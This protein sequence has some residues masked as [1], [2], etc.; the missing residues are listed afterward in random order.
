MQSATMQ[1]AIISRATVRTLPPWAN[2]ED[3]SGSP[4]LDTPSST[5]PAISAGSTNGPAATSILHLSTPSQSSIPSPLSHTQQWSQFATMSQISTISERASRTPDT[6]SDTT[7]LLQLQE[8]ADT[9]SDSRF[10]RLPQRLDKIFGGSARASAAGGAS[11]SNTIGPLPSTTCSCDCNC[12]KHR[13]TTTRTRQSWRTGE[14]SQ[15]LLSRKQTAKRER[16]AS[17]GYPTGEC[18]S[19]TAPLVTNWDQLGGEDEKLAESKGLADYFTN[20]AF[21]LDAIKLLLAS[22]LFSN[23]LKILTVMAAVSLFAIALDAII[24]LQNATEDEKTLTQL[25]ND[26]AALV[27]TI[28]FSLC[29]ILYS[30]LNIYLDSRRSPEGLVESRTE[31][32][33]LFIIFSEIMAS[34]A[35]AQ[36]LSVTIYIYIWTFGCTEAGERQLEKL[37]KQNLDADHR[38]NARMCRRQGAMVGLELLLILLLIFNFYTHLS[39]NF[40]FIR[41][42]SR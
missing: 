24:L 18:V 38:L 12:L 28:V 13:K 32:K 37:W 42:V 17:L 8:D 25:W 29:T 15:N 19:S 11:N 4:A 9:P 41:S 22:P 34:I 33:P 26:S 7:T 1:Q 31:S 3:P 21:N 40:Q 35:W 6:S 2:E 30:C 14:S 20:E 5:P 23:F 39:Q 27:I 10:R 36:V 16:E